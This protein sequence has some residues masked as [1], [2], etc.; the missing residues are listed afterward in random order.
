MAGPW[1]VYASPVEQVPW[2]TFAA[3]RTAAGIL[4]ALQAGWQGGGTGLAVRGKLPDV[5]LDPHHAEWYEKAAAGVSQVVTELPQMVAG[6]MLGRAAGAV[7]GAPFG[8]KGAVV[9][10]VL[11]SGAGAF[12]VPAA[13]RSSLIEAYKSGTAES[14]GG[15]LASAKIILKHTGK[16]SL[17]G[18]LTLGA[19][20]VVGRGVAAAVAPGVGTTLTA[21]NATR[22]I[23]GSSAVSEL[24][25]MV[26]AGSALEGKL[27]EWEDFLNAA[28]VLGGVKASVKMAGKI[29]DIYART[30]ASPEEVV[31]VARTRPEVIEE[32]KA[33]TP[34]LPKVFQEAVNDA[35]AREAILDPAAARA[36][37]KK[38]FAEIPQ[39]PGT[40]KVKLNV[41]YDYI[42]TP[43]EA[44]AALARA[45]ELYGPAIL[46]QTRGKVSW[47]ATE[48]QAKQ[49]LS[50]MTGADIKKLVTEREPGT[51]ANAVELEIRS[52]AMLGAVEDFTRKAQAYD[53]AKSGPEEALAM[54]AAGER[55]AMLSAF[56]QG[57]ASEA[58]RAT[59]Y[60]KRVKELRGQGEAITELLKTTDPAAIARIMR[61]I[62]N[63]VAAA[64]VARD[65]T[66]AT[67]WE[68]VVEGLKSAM[69]SGPISVGA[70]IIGNATFLPL[71][72]IIDAAAVPLGMVLRDPNRVQAVEPVARIIGNYQGMVDAL[73]LAGSFIRVFGDRPAME[74][75]RELDKGAGRKTESQKRAIGGDLGVVVRLPFLAL[76]IPDQLFRLMHER[77]EANAIAA[78]QASKEG[79]TPGSREFGERMAEVRQ[80]LTEEQQAS[81]EALGARGT[82]NADLGKIGRTAQELVKAS[83]SEWLFPFVRTPANIAKELLRLTPAAPIIDTWRADIAKGGAPA[84][85]ALA[86][87]LVGGGIAAVVVGLA[88]AGK[89]TGA[90]EPDPNKKRVQLAAG[91][92]PYSFIT[93]GGKAFELS[94]LQPIGTLIGLAADMSEMWDRMEAGEQDKVPKMLAVAFANAITNQTMLLGLSNLV[95]AV[96]EPDRFGARFV[97]GLAAMP[98][99]GFVSQT[100]QLNDPYMREIHSILD[101]VKNRLPGQRQTLEPKVDVWGELIENRE[102]VGGVGPSRTMQAS[103]DKV[104]T[105]AARLG[106]S[107]PKPE[108]DIALAVKMKVDPKLAKVEL[109]PV[110]QTQL[111]I[112]AGQKAHEIMSNLVGAQDWDGRS[113][114]VKKMIYQ[115]VFGRARTYARAQILSP[116]QRQFETDRIVTEI[117]R[118]LAAP[119]RL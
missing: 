84:Q 9:G 82:F 1:D 95:R 69:I 42:N 38:P 26:V 89:I 27:P 87:M 71:R 101:A 85:K 54:M 72:P 99:P 36:F 88:N 34:E 100:A 52:Q 31:A 10:A 55:V 70:N 4:D 59:N 73:M 21:K 49:R 11:G 74:A 14:S 61:E 58:G 23:E 103:T 33:E 80:N 91:K 110:Q 41:N 45:S 16:E 114:L 97:Q 22:V 50:E 83:H 44:K 112:M 119:A 96:S 78:R 6:G 115:D 116:E 20:A 47:E 17:I 106:V 67:T 12:A 30:G 29:G 5:V 65:I 24:G 118:Q 60:M 86:E 3:P 104:K 94:R 51:A 75:L 35:N 105:E 39:E 43:E 57:A 32:L 63:P 92:Q 13:I 25:T 76:S 28:I 107:V 108:D 111:A 15:F 113:D 18:A 53:P 19:G 56:F 7:A 81:V 46:E 109:T 64:R 77:G 98:V 117:R 90:G 66:K 93:E 37:V 68:K 2:E 102:R 40:P 62:D 8:P 79:L 48:Q